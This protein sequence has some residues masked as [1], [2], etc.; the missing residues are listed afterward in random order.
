VNVRNY[1]YDPTCFRNVADHGFAEV[2]SDEQIRQAIYQAVS[3]LPDEDVPTV[4]EETFLKDFLIRVEDQICRFKVVP[5]EYADLEPRYA[6]NTPLP[7]KTKWTKDEIAQVI[8]HFPPDRRYLA[9]AYNVLYATDMRH[10]GQSGRRFAVPT[11]VDDFV[12]VPMT[13]TS[14]ELRTKEKPTAWPNEEKLETIM[15]KLSMAGWRMPKGW[16][17]YRTSVVQKG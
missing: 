17:L 5:L 3:R 9:R 14:D 6:Y 16:T 8:A 7:G 12:V 1:L 11:E 10:P 15:H 13:V 2:H 4:F